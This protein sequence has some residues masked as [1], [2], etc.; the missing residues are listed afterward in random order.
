MTTDRSLR[1]KSR[2][3]LPFSRAG[4]PHAP[5]PLR[6]VGPGSVLAQGSELLRA[7]LD[8][9][10]AGEVAVERISGVRGHDEDVHVR[11]APP[12]RHQPDELGIED[13]GEASPDPVRQ[14]EDIRRLA[15]GRIG[16][17]Q[18]APPGESTRGT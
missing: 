10:E 18:D 8:V 5:D 17:E 12:A 7:L 2:S 3:L 6:G 11:D 4:R 1:D 13:P 16:P 14:L 9:L 15:A